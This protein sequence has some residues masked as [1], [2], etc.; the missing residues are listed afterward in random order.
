MVILGAFMSLWGGE[1]EEEEEEE[2]CVLDHAGC[3]LSESGCFSHLSEGF[4]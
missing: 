1:E 3:I 4:T 2:D